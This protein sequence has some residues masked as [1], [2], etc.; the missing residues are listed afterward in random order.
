MIQQR[1]FNFSLKAM[2]L[3]K[4]LIYQKEFVISKQFLKSA[5]SIGANIEEALAGE[6]RKDFLH[7]MAIS[8][9]ESREARYWLRIL[10]ESQ[11]IEKD[12]S[13]YLKEIE[14]IINIL[15]KIVKTTSHNL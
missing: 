1:S 3:Y 2:E 6:S 5:T 4:I 13:V 12:Y 14:I 7:K 10:E 9:K 8:L 15:T 11:I